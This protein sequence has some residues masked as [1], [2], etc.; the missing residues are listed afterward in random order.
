M[1]VEWNRVTVVV[2]YGVGLMGNLTQ[3]ITFTSHCIIHAGT[4]QIHCNII[5][6]DDVLAVYIRAVEER[7]AGDIGNPKNHLKSW[8]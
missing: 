4:V 7:N 1:T 3:G 8:G 6:V 2:G 5:S